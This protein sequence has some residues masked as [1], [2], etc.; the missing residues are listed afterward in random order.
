[1]IEY[2]RPSRSVSK[3]LDPYIS[4]DSLP[5]KGHTSSRKGDSDSSTSFFR[6]GG[7]DNF[8]GSLE[9]FDFLSSGISLKTTLSVP[10]VGSSRRSEGADALF[11]LILL[12]Q[13][14]L[15]SL[16]L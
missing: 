12:I 5:D 13:L 9:M 15:G 7:G 14:V 11:M 4:D 16:V 6:D 3:L 2:A 1:M 10:F 8:W